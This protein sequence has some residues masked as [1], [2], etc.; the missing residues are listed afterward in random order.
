MTSWQHR[1]RSDEEGEG[2]GVGG[3][4]GWYDDRCESV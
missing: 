1:S 4:R 3:E 2:R